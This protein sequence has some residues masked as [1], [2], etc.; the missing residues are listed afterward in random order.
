VIVA[1]GIL[2]NACSSAPANSALGE[3]DQ[4]EGD[5]SA[6]VS[7]VKPRPSTPSQDPAP[8][9]TDSGTV[10]DPDGGLAPAPDAAVPP[11]P[12]ADCSATTSYDACDQCC[13]TNN[14]PGYK[15]AN[16]AFM[17][18]ICQAPG[19]CAQACGG[20]FCAG[21]EPSSKC[22]QCLGSQAAGQ[23]EDTAAAACDANPACTASNQCFQT[24]GCEQKP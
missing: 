10:V 13:D 2:A 20:S 1:G 15:I 21:Q 9:D 8:A 23:C 14:P 12:Q 11:G 16:D 4:T 19:V 6:P 22:E 5:A 24:S 7:N 18:C 17:A 3:D